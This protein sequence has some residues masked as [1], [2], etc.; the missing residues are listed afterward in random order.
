MDFL[1]IPII[2]TLLI[3]M[4]SAVDLVHQIGV[5]ILLLLEIGLKQS[6]VNSSLQ[7]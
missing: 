4:G 1:A 2:F 7:G 6:M 3:G 5:R